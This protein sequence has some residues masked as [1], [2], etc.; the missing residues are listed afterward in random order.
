MNLILTMAGKYSRFKN[1]GYR[2]PKFLLPWGSKTILSEILYQ[3]S[4]HFENIFLIANE[5]DSDYLVHVKHIMNSYNI[6]ENNLFTIQ[7]TESQSETLLCGIKNFS[8]ILGPIIVHN[9]DTILYERDYYLIQNELLTKDGFID[10]FDSNNPNY[11][12]V[13]E[14]ENKVISI[15]EKTL[16]SN[17]ASSGMYGFSSIDLIKKYYVNGYISEIYQKM[18]NDDLEISVGKKYTTDNTVVLGTPKEYQ[19]LS[20]LK[21]GNL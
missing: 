21:L 14:N 12:Y 9:I 3:M 17:N 7:D 6:G 15:S 13:V 1:D 2:V 11:S 4:P 16:I 20:F 19:S 18:L 10:I 8:N 5:N